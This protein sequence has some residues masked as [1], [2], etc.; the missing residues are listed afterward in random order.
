MYYNSAA[1]SFFSKKLC[2]RLHSIEV[3]FKKRKS[4]F[5]EPPFGRLI[6]NVC[7]SS[8]ARWKARVWLPI[9]RNWT[10]FASSYCWDVTGGNLSTW[11]IFEGG[12]NSIAD[13]RW[14]GTS[15][16]NHCWV[17]ENLKDCPFVWY[18]NIAGRFFGLV[19]KTRA[20]DR[21]TDGQ[22]DGQNYDSQDRASIAASCGKNAG[23]AL[24]TVILYTSLR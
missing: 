19:T 13:F 6:G 2:S 17:A 24:C 12:G 8:I 14:K 18:K 1:G 22:T 11:A 9:R 3:L 16:T 21:R 15:P 23:G 20:T 10:F 4:S 5:F 7:T